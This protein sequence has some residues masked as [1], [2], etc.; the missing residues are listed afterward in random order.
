MNSLP[1][2]TRAKVSFSSAMRLVSIAFTALA[3]RKSVHIGNGTTAPESEAQVR[4]RSCAVAAHSDPMTLDKI[5]RFF[6]RWSVLLIL[7]AILGAIGGFG[8]HVLH[9][10]A[11]FGLLDRGLKIRPMVLPDIFQDQDAP[12]KQYEQAG[13]NARHIVAKALE[14][15]FGEEYRNYRKGTWF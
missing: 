13:L 2:P 1:S 12:V 15:R 7:A 6:L 9:H 11:T 10:L 8:S 4:T 14:A 5:L 3:S